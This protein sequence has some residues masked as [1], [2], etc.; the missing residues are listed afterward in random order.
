MLGDMGLRPDEL[1]ALGWADVD[2][3]RLQV[4][5][6]DSKTASGHRTVGMTRAVAEMFA[7]RLWRLGLRRRQ[8]RGLVFATRTGG[9]V[10]RGLWRKFR[11]CLRAA[12]IEADDVCVYSLRKLFVSRVLRKRRDGRRG[13]SIEAARALVGHK[14]AKMTVEVYGQ[15]LSDDQAAAIAS[16]DHDTAAGCTHGPNAARK[17]GV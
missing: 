13:G 10:L 5:I 1:A 6:R 9:S 12:G 16:I 17:L 14:T 8:A 4:R 2:L 7:R 11:R 15:D 3:A